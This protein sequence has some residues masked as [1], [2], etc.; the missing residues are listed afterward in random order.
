MGGRST[1]QAYISGKIPKLLMLTK[2][3]SIHN[4]K[5]ELLV[6]KLERL[7][8]DRGIKEV[9]IS[10]VGGPCLAAGSS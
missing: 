7:L 6:D 9:D 8:A 5:Y 10:A 3:L 1:K 2:G 4:N